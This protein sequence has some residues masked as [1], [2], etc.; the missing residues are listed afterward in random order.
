MSNFRTLTDTLKGFDL[1]EYIKELSKYK[2]VN[3]QDQ[4]GNSLL[5]Y[6]VINCN[7]PALLYTMSRK[8]NLN[9]QNN[10]KIT[11][12]TYAIWTGFLPI[13][14]ALLQAGA[15]TDVV[16]AKGRSPLFFAVKRNDVKAIRLLLDFGAKPNEVIN[17]KS[18]LSWAAELGNDE[19]ITLL[20]EAG[21]RHDVGNVPPLISCLKSGSRPV[22][23]ALTEKNPREVLSVYNEKSILQH[24]IEKKTTLLPLIANL[25]QEEIQKM[26]DA[27]EPNIPQF[28]P[29]NLTPAQLKRLNIAIE[30][31]DSVSFVTYTPPD[32]HQI[33]HL[34]QNLY[35]RQ[36]ESTIASE[37]QSQLGNDLDQV[38]IVPTTQ[39]VEPNEQ[40][41][42]QSDNNRSDKASEQKHDDGAEQESQS[43]SRASRA[44]HSSHASQASQA[45]K[46]SQASRASQASKHSQASQGSRASAKQ[47]P[48]ARPQS[49]AQSDA[50]ES[51][52]DDVQ[53]VQPKRVPIL[54]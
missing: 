43:G 5:H 46:A 48:V 51:E 45:S 41:E 40:Q 33:R 14:A 35:T 1:E 18:L 9:I 50:E 3:I 44:S 42:G 28:P 27:G 13:A 34:Y 47:T 52:D 23:M 29:P 31:N 32:E 24:A 25:V 8:A 26:K 17:E 16:D 19:A 7:Y 10:S 30:R 53:V 39:V 2:N 11:P 54:A 21:A 20:V 22:L 12:L 37:F 36:Q 6:C 15:S 4:D 38:Q 49:N